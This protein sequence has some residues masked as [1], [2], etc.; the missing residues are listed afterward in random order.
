MVILDLSKHQG[1][2]VNQASS[3][4]ITSFTR[5]E[6]SI[7]GR[8]NGDLGGHCCEP[9][10][11]H[12]QGKRWTRNISNARLQNL[13]TE[14]YNTVPNI[15]YPP[16][17]AR[18][19][20]WPSQRLDCTGEQ[21]EVWW[22]A[23]PWTPLRRP[24]L[25]FEE[26][27]TARN[28]KSRNTKK[29]QCTEPTTVVRSNAAVT[30]WRHTIGIGRDQRVRHMDTSRTSTP[31]EISDDDTETYLKPFYLLRNNRRLICVFLLRTKERT[32]SRR[33]A[34]PLWENIYRVGSDRLHKYQL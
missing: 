8:R 5:V 17:H 20:R 2:S 24:D 11:S 12:W 30:V 13:Y 15:A 9:R 33:F 4:I 25:Q 34:C 21:P 19:R 31:A 27:Y 3:S 32:S 6:V 23:L 16:S 28:R 18:I 7:M 22:Q 10:P 14:Q 26:Y 1:T 29:Q